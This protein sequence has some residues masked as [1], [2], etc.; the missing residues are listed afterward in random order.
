M[1]EKEQLGGLIRDWKDERYKGQ[2]NWSF[3][4]HFSLFGSIAMSLVAAIAV[5]LSFS[6]SST[7]AT[8]AAA[9]AAALT[10]LAT[11]GGFESKWRSNRVSR[12]AA[13]IL[14]I[15]LTSPEADLDSIRRKFIEICEG[16]DQ[17]IVAKRKNS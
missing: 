15:Q 11:S 6:D 3:I 2:K 10:G 1:E 13:D 12:S 14:L 7:L 9:I 4:H 16:H 17:E 8:I 5:Q